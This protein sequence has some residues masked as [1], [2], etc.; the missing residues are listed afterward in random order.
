MEL[1]GVPILLADGESTITVKLKQTDESRLDVD[2][3]LGCVHLLLSPSHVH[4][5][6]EMVKNLAANGEES[7]G[8]I[9]AC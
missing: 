9:P 7:S 4:M 8:N 2:M 3:A 5:M 6:A 1:E